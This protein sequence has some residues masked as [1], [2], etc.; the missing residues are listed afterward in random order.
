MLINII[1]LIVIVIILIAIIFVIV[2]IFI[3]FIATVIVMI[4]STVGLP[5]LL[6]PLATH[7]RRRIAKVRIA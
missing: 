3:V 7:G 5:E 6:A 4:R 1:F 2:I